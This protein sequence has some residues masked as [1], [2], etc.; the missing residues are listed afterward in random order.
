MSP[1]QSGQ[2][3]AKNVEQQEP[4]FISGGMQNGVTTLGCSLGVPNK[5]KHT[6]TI[7]YSNHNSW[8]SLCI[9]SLYPYNT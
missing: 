3:T 6:L 1:K 2:N 7:Q 4:L 8:Y 9:G 5:T